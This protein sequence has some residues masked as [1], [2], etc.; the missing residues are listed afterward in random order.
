MNRC[1]CSIIIAAAFFLPIQ[2]LSREHPS[3]SQL[4]NEY[5]KTQDKLKS[6][7]ITSETSMSS[8]TNHEISSSQGK[9]HYKVMRAD[10][11]YDGDR[12]SVT[13][14]RWLDMDSPDQPLTKD[15]DSYSYS[16]FMWDGKSGWS[17]S[18]GPRNE[19]GIVI[20][21]EGADAKKNFTIDKSPVKRMM[22][23]LL[24]DSERVD[25]VLSKADGVFVRDTMEK[26]GDFECYVI[27]A[28][29]KRGK[30][31]LWIDP[32][33]G[34]NIARAQISR[35]EGDIVFGKPLGS[36]F[37]I[38]GSFEVVRF[39]QNGDV[40]IPMEIH[41]RGGS[42]WPGGHFSKGE[43]HTKNTLVTLNP[44][45]E[46]LGSFVLDE[47]RN[48]ATVHILGVPD[49]TYTWR[50]GKVV[51][52]QGREVD[53]KVLK[54]K[55]PVS[56]VGKP[57]PKLSDLGIHVKSKQTKGMMVLVAFWD[58]NQRPSRNCVQRL[59]KRAKL[60]EKKGVKVVLA[61]CGQVDERTINGWLKKS[62]IA[63]SVG[64]ITR[65]IQHIRE[66]WGVQSLPWLILADRNHVV[67]EEGFGI[68]ELNEKI[69]ES[70]NVG[71]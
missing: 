13:R 24:G 17:Y 29:T 55:E 10:V 56:L 69:K 26:V 12:M 34:Y 7:M 6:F 60:L 30:Y 33:H 31:A 32:A 25:Q 19:L 58:M 16:R 51:D 66:T 21:A 63:L 8:A 14:N 38:V 15:S 49:I 5:A 52:A 37:S 70:E 1:M 39:E 57:L 27:E 48:G 50:E 44:D 54:S 35:T 18:K 53:L 68:R 11:R 47:V 3:V 43:S 45:H 40:W 20:K 36:E 41:S 46:A 22:G 61:H 59:N 23:M 2:A 64:R 4:L 67:I 62:Q 28:D 65:N 42:K 9:T 71:A